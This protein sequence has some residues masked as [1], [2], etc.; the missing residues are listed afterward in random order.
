MWSPYLPLHATN[1]IRDCTPNVRMGFIKAYQRGRR[2][3]EKGEGI[4]GV[5]KQTREIYSSLLAENY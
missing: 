4:E 5:K 2:G 1:M 3:K